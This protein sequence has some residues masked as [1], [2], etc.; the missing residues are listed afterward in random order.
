[1]HVT[2]KSCY[3]KLIL[4][5]THNLPLLLVWEKSMSMLR[6][7]YTTKHRQTRLNFTHR[8][9][10]LKT[11]PFHK[12]NYT[13]WTHVLCSKARQCHFLT[14]NHT[15]IV[16]AVSSGCDILINIYIYIWTQILLKT[17]IHNVKFHNDPA[18]CDMVSVYYIATILRH[19]WTGADTLMWTLS[20]T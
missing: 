11:L 20:L 15:H 12:P 2:W 7:N 18:S 8:P 5:L 19:A 13:T 10:N 4:I 1:M 6:L 17:A 3:H 9:R 16:W 14:E